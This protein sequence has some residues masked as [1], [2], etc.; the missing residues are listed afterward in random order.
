MDIHVDTGGWYA[1]CF[2]PGMNTALS[3]DA[4]PL[5]HL[6]IINPNTS[7]SVTDLLCRH[8]QPVAQAQG[9]QLRAVTARL[10]APYI[11]CEASYAVAAHSAL[12]AW[13]AALAVPEPAPQAVLLACF[14]DPGLL[15]LREASAVPVTGLAEASFI[16]ARRLGRFAIVTGGARW[17]PMLQRLAQQLGYAEAL[18]GIHT[19]A[20]S[21]AEMAAN[22]LAARALLAQACREAV[23]QWG[24]QSVVLGGAGLA[25]QAAL[26]QDTV[27]VPVI[28]SV[29]AGLRVLLGGQGPAGAGRSVAGFF[30]RWQ[31]LSPELQALGAAP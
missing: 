6:L 5:R 2:G 10:G 7:A 4:G 18:A 15:A 26:L 12:D 25:G 13:A 3:S 27:P 20:P 17:A 30:T 1:L 29:Q 8:A 24:V 9:W 11:S 14:G 31:G 21:G 22:P 28:D 16:E 23:A 19:V